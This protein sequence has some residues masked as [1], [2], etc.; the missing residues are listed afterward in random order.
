M[1]RVELASKYVATTT[2]TSIV[3][4]L[5]FAKGFAQQPAFP[6]TSQKVSLILF[7]VKIS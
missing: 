5:N 1:A 7:D 4:D 3:I 2:S 6:L